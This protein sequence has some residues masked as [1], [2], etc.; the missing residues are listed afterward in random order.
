MG[1]TVAL[2]AMGGDFGPQV[3]VPAVVQALLHFP[4]LK[5]TL[6]GDQ[7]AITTQLTLLNQ[8][9]HPRITIVHSNSAIANDARPSQALRRSH[10]SSM[11]MALEAVS[12]GNADACVS[13]GNT[14]ALMALSRYILKQL[15]GID[16]PALVSAIP[17]AA[18]TKTWI[19]D[20]GANV[21]CDSDTLFQFAVMGAVLAEQWLSGKPRIALLNIGEEEI[22]GND[23]V[24][25]CAEMLSQCDDIDYIGYIEGDKLYSGLADVIVCDGFVGNVSLKTSEGVAHLF[26]GRIRQAVGTSK[27]KQILAKWLFSD[28]FDSLKQLNPDQYNGASLLGLRGIVVKSHGSAD[29]TA[30]TNAIS[31]AVYEVERQ[32]P[33]KISNRLEEVLLERHY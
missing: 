2:D 28:L 18:A 12:E 25:R 26:I 7:S 22:K 8:L 29:I 9:N 5:V 14:G 20:L 31:E 16:R 3:T 17:T 21:S 4:E 23:L 6:F 1:L 15:P 30:F 32:I 13:A 10:G 19:L 11:R 24:K 33:T 27:F